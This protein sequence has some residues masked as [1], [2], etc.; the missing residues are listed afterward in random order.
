KRGRSALALVSPHTPGGVPT[1]PTETISTAN[2]PVQ[3]NRDRSWRCCSSRPRPQRPSRRDGFATT[4]PP[5]LHFH[6]PTTN[7]PSHSA[8]VRVDGRHPL[9]PRRALVKLEG[10][11]VATGGWYG[12]GRHPGQ[13]REA[14]P[15]L[16]GAGDRLNPVLTFVSRRRLG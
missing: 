10:V 11:P 14:R 8:T 4:T 1:G 12:R 9:H 16:S 3:K 13:A 5:R 2:S 7:L 6:G 15:A